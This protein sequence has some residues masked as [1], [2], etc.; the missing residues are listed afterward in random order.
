MPPSR[1]ARRLHADRTA[2]GGGADRGHR[3]RRGQRWRCATA[4]P[5]SSSE[6]GARLAALLEMARA[7]A[8]AS[9]LCRCAASRRAE[10]APTRAQLPLRRPA[11]RR[12]P[13]HALA[14][15]RR[16]AREVVGAR[17]LRA[18]PRADRC[19]RSASCCAWTTSALDAGHATAWARSPCAARPR[20]DAAMQRRRRPRRLHADRGAGRAGHR[21]RRAGRRAA[22]PPAR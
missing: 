6:E 1:A 5:R 3:R 11:G 18:R 21:G 4:T 10:R 14:G 13:A 16:R 17:A 9:G 20:R 12:G 19:R 22:A 7:E 8:R 2:G 15:R